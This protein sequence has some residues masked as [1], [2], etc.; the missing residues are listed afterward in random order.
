MNKSKYRPDKELILINNKYRLNNIM[1]K[2]INKNDYNSIKEMLEDKQEVIYQNSK[3][4]I[5]KKILTPQKIILI[6]RNIRN[7][8]I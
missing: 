7:N 2:D 4:N 8:I 6:K 5:A 1:Q 3:D